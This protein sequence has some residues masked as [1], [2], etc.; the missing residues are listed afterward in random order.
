MKRMVTIQKLLFALAVALCSINFSYGQPAAK[1][2]GGA[3]LSISKNRVKTPTV[4]SVKDSEPEVILMSF[5]ISRGEVFSSSAAGALTE[6]TLS[7]YS[8][9]MQ[10]GRLSKY[11]SLP[12]GRVGELSSFSSM[13]SSTLRGQTTLNECGATAEINAVFCLWPVV[14][15][16]GL[17]LTVTVDG[18]R[19]TAALPFV[20]PDKC[21]IAGYDYL[22]TLVLNG[23][24]LSVTGVTPIKL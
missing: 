7:G 8:L 18:V 23:N 9:D 2:G 12:T 16:S 22:Y 1:S 14:T 21:W 3:S 13:N 11:C 15:S 10:A 20:T 24:L 6:V 5:S 17:N 19:Y 4:T